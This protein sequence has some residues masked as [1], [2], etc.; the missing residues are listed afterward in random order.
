VP[1]TPAQGVGFVIGFWAVLVLLFPLIAPRAF[2]SDPELG[3]LEAELHRSVN[4][5]RATLHLVELER[6]SDL[7]EVARAH[8]A[9]MAAR[10]FFSHDTPEG[11]NPVHRL[12]R[13]GVAGF[14]LAGENVGQTNRPGPNE[15]ILEGWKRSPVHRQNL[16]AGPFNATGV[17]IARA[18]DGTLFY[19]QLYASFP[20]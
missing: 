12:Q 15:E 5:F 4:A 7:D 20:R 19:T 10:G 16:T 13:A 3:S 11:L 17:G 2:A 1:R 6:R 18:A 9:D 14:A 8:S